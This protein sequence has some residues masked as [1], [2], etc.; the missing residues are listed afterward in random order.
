MGCVF[1]VC[2]YGGGDRRSQCDICREGV[3]VVIATPGRLND[4]VC[5]AVI[6]LRSVTFLVRTHTQ[7]EREG[8]YCHGT[9]Q[10]CCRQSWA[11]NFIKSLLPATRVTRCKLSK[12]RTFFQPEKKNSST[13]EKNYPKLFRRLP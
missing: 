5:N 4:L 9:L 8:N 1:S 10:R 13:R 11:G 3:E 12:S 2:V 7:R 6:D